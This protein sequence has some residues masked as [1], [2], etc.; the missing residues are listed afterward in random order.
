MIKAMI[1]DYGGVLDTGK[2]FRYFAEK[3]AEEFNK[4]PE[5]LHSII[6]KYWRPARTEKISSGEFWEGIS[7][8]LKCD[9]EHFE[10][11]M[12]DFTVVDEEALELVKLLKKKYKLALLSNHIRDWLEEYI[13]KNNLREIFDLIVTS[14]DVGIEKPNT[15]IYE[16]TIEKL[17]VEPEECVFIDDQGVNLPPAEELGMKAILFRDVDQL[18]KELKEL[19]VDF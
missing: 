17:G 15:G 3:H 10:F 18:K 12:K 4:T 9:R 14:Y 5:E 1:F 16:K 6:K 7:R 11:L 13:D 2:G 8:E 19:G